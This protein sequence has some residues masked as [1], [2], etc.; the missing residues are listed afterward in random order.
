MRTA[1]FDESRLDLIKQSLR[2]S[3]M[4]QSATPAVCHLARREEFAAI[5]PTGGFARGWPAG[6]RLFNLINHLAISW[7][8]VAS[9][10]E[11]QHK[12]D[13]DTFP[14]PKKAFKRPMVK[15]LR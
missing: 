11:G 8:I 6:C 3:V 10:N 2:E 7:L 12:V 9:H 1:F 13:E 14:Q 15:I 4:L 5:C